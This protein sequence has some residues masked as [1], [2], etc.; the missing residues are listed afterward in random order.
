MIQACELRTQEICLKMSVSH[1]A[2][3]C[4]I[5]I[6]AEVLDSFKLK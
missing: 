5:Y 3:S 4:Y 1:V 6:A 2:P